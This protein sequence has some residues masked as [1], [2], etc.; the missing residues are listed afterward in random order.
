L[1]AHEKSHYKSDNPNGTND[2]QAGSISRSALGDSSNPRDYLD[3]ETPID[4]Y[5]LQELLKEDLITISQKLNS[6]GFI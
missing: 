1:A 2:G 4:Q 6:E 5:N 3:Q